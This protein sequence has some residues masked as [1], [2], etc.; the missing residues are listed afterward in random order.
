MAGALLALRLWTPQGETSRGQRP[1]LLVCCHMTKLALVPG[2]LLAALPGLAQSAAPA[3]G[4]AA[5]RTATQNALFEEYFQTQLRNAPELATNLGDYRYND[6]LGDVSLAEIKREKAQDDAFLARLQA[7]STDGMTEQD[8]LSHDLLVQTLQVSDQS[9]ALKNYEMPVNQMSSP[10][11]NLADLPLQAPF[12]SVRHYEDYIARLKQIPRVFDQTI[13]VMR[14]GE[15]DGLMPVKF[16]LEQV[17]GQCD[18]V[19]A[20]DPYLLPT[21]KYPASISAADQ[22]R[23][24]A[25]INDAIQTQVFPAYRKFAAFVRTDY[26]PLGRT[27]LGISSLPDGKRRYALAIREGVTVDLPP[28]QIHQIGL[29]EVKRITEK[30][31]ALAVQ[32]GFKDLAAWR[33]AINADPRWRPT[34]ADQIVGDFRKYIAGMQ[35]ELPKLFNLLPEQAVTVEPMPSFQPNNAT[36][37]NPGTPDGSR[38]GRVVVAVSNPTSRTLVDDEATAYHE[39]IPGHHMQISVSQRLTGL[40]KFRTQL[41]FYTAYVEG[42]ALYAEELGK[43]VGFYKDPVSDYG[44]LNSELFRAVRLVVDTGIHDGNWTRQ[45]VVD[46][47]LSN[48]VVNTLAQSETDRYIAWPGQALAYKMGQLKIRELRERAKAQLGPRFDIKAFHDEILNGG[49]LPLDMLEARVNRW[50]ASQMPAN[51]GVSTQDPLSGHE[52][53]SVR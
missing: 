2:F 5:A 37:Y 41:S 1:S 12:D 9:Y 15:H 35:P 30:M 43:E 34:G 46:Y 39:G 13:E 25:A 6:R 22:T 48:D 32:Q 17:P 23:L 18:G 49:A 42:W 44:R 10:P 31:N 7:I 51:A 20:S 8:R 33:T 27:Q 26:A 47:M 45:Q 4:E 11:V 16:L 14:A 3:G 29:D 36:H 38:P 40:P 19:I 28:A 53:H 21:K 52:S 50:I 24:T